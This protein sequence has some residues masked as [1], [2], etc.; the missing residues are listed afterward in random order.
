MDIQKYLHPITPDTIVPKSGVL[1]FEFIRFKKP[2]NS[3]SVAIAY[4]MR[5]NGNIE[6]K[7]LKICIIY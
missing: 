1:T 3:P 6:P 2:N 5:G 7:R 4:K